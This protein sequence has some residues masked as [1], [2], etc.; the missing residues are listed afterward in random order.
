MRE[1]VAALARGD[2][3]VAKAMKATT[4]LTDGRLD[5]CLHVGSLHKT[6]RL[7]SAWLFASV[8]KLPRKSVRKQ[9]T[10]HDSVSTPV[11]ASGCLS[12]KSMGGKP[13]RRRQPG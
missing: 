12:A 13:D 9:T 3:T 4:T 5:K 11:S 6:S 7:V 1:A 8:A 2:P 10:E